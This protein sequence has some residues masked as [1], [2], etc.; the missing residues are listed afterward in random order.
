MDTLLPLGKAIGDILCWPKF[1]NKNSGIIKGGGW[2]LLRHISLIVKSGDLF[3]HTCMEK[4][5]W[6]SKVSYGK[7]CST[8]MPIG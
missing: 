4:A 2:A 5:H 7:W 3:A 8:Q 1:Q 6:R